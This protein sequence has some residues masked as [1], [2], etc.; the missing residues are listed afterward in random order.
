MI[1]PEAV[2]NR[3]GYL[4]PGVRV[5]R[6]M[7]SVDDWHDLPSSTGHYVRNDRGPWQ[8]RI[9]RSDQT[10]GGKTAGGVSL[11]AKRAYDLATQL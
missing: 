8:E 4:L 7:L 5:G 6:H 3:L 10:F 1:Y 2:S 11:H 9:Q